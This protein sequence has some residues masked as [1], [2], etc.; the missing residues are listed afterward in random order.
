MSNGA[1]MSLVTYD[2][3]KNNIDIIITRVNS[4]TN[5]MPPAG[6]LPASTRNLFQQ[7]KDDGLLEN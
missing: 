7:W 6:Q 1:P 2:Q 4:T 5:P 3:V